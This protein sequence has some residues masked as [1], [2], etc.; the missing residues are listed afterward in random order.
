MAPFF[1]PNH[2]DPSPPA[3]MH[4]KSLYGSPSAP[5]WKV[6]PSPSWQPTPASVANHSRPCASTAPPRTSDAAH[7]RPCP[8]ETVCVRYNP[9]SSR[10]NNPASVP[11]TS[12]SGP[13]GAHTRTSIRSVSP[14][15]R[16]SIR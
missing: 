14:S 9:S 6:H 2:T 11:S 12:G 16:G 1:V 7:C 8:S 5:V 3:A 15:C 13:S 10:K 4:V